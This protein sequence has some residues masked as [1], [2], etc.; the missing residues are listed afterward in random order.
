MTLILFTRSID[1]SLEESKNI[2]IKFN[3]ITDPYKGKNY[4]IPL[5]FIKS[6]V[7]F[8][9][10]RGT[11]KFDFSRDMFFSMKSS[12]FGAAIKSS[13]YSLL[14]L[15]SS[16]YTSFYIL[17][18][19]NNCEEW[20][21]R[22]YNLT[23]E[24]NPESRTTFKFTE[25][26]NRACG[27]LSIVKDPELKN[28]VIAMLDYYSQVFLKPIHNHLFKCLRKLPCDRTFTQAPEFGVPLKKGNHKL[29]SLDL[30]A[31]TD[32]FPIKL[33][34]KLIRTIFNYDISSNWVNILINR[35]FAYT[36]PLL[37]DG[38]YETSY[39]RYSVGQPMGAYSSWAAFT[40]SHHLVVCWCAY[41][42]G[43]PIGSF[44][45][46]ILLGDDIVINHNKVAQRYI[47]VMTKLGV[48]ISLNKTHV[49]Y[50]TYEFAKR[51]I[52]RGK[53]ITGLPIG[54]IIRNYES[55]K[56]VLTII[57]D[58][59][60]KLKIGIPCLDI[61]AKF[62]DGIVKNNTKS[63]K[64]FKMTY[65][66]TYKYLYHYNIAIRFR[67]NLITL[68]E[69]RSYIM[70]M[71]PYIA[72]NCDIILLLKVS[73]LGSCGAL[74][75]KGLGKIIKSCFEYSK[76][77]SILYK[78]KR[79]PTFKDFAYFPMFHALLNQIR[80]SLEKIFSLKD[81][82]QISNREYLDS[83]IESTVPDMDT[84]FMEK[85]NV[86][87]MSEALD[88]L[89][90]GAIETIRTGSEID[91]YGNWSKML[92]GL[93]QGDILDLGEDLVMINFSSKLWKG[94]YDKPFIPGVYDPGMD[95]LPSLFK[96]DWRKRLL[97]TEPP[98]HEF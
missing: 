65:K 55:P 24:F 9:G 19:H 79:R 63:K 93:Q 42:E 40:L 64:S 36:G 37:S 96:L 54:G 20:L 53:E 17:C 1:P 84:Y 34:E 22:L 90:K 87:K 72:V 39:Y 30:S 4:T 47:K 95:D 8:Y 48:E 49:S 89:W 94:Y 11:Y 21:R 86:K 3:T 98:L 5:A 88:K 51:W 85:R 38:G 12:P 18:K 32:R 56:A 23:W 10:F 7:D 13:F 14:G 69:I 52:S 15:S 2:Q 62:Y 78:D 71:N 77:R 46:Y 83:F 70:G 66:S 82:K 76:F 27:K 43:Y 58:Y 91:L 44:S 60:V 74:L 61:V 80:P 50:D 41:L 33:Q 81:L 28:R 67:L 26:A 31:A 57:Y 73:L 25:G 45:N 35:D 6:F 92:F 75:N 68:D 29:W 97:E 16:L 59:M